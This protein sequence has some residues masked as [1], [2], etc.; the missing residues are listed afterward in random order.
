MRLFR[1]FCCATNG[2]SIF[3]GL[4]LYK[5][6]VQP[7][8]LLFKDTK[9][10]VHELLAL[11]DRRQPLT[12]AVSALQRANRD[13]VRS[14]E[15]RF[16]L[17]LKIGERV[18]LKC[19]IKALV[20]VP[21]R[22]FHFAIMP[23]RSGLDQL[24]LDSVLLAEPVQRVQL[25][26]AC[27]PRVRKLGSVVSLYDL[28]LITEIQK[29]S[30]EEIYRIHCRQLF[31]SI[32]KALPGCLVYNGILKEVPIG[33]DGVSPALKRY[34]LDVELPFLPDLLRSIVRLRRVWLFLRT[35][36]IETLALKVT[37]EGCRVPGV[38]V[39][40]TKLTVELIESDI[41]GSTYE[42]E[43]MT[44]LLGCLFFRMR[45]Q[46]T[47]RSVLKALKRSVV[48]TTPPTKRSVGTMITMT[49]EFR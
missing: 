33:K 10:E 32:D 36:H 22:T 29:G 40:E 46:R 27:L 34:K 44:L 48:L 42:V 18:K 12:F 23:G 39:I 13:I 3:G 2:P 41:R 24:M 6:S 7:A 19:F 1:A 16:H 15:V 11:L 28:R 47:V 20:V 31:V 30:R 25:I 17:L 9:I 21:V 14:S 37:V 45:S 26:Q 38:T 5:Y 35:V 4:F 49:H 43:Y 8:E